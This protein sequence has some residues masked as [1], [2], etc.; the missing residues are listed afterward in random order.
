MCAYKSCISKTACTCAYDV[1]PASVG[2]A[3]CRSRPAHQRSL[4]SQ[5]VRGCFRGGRAPSATCFVGAHPPAGWRREVRSEQQK[6]V[7]ATKKGTR[8]KQRVQATKKG[9]YCV[10]QDKTCQVS[11]IWM[12][13]PDLGA[14]TR[15][16]YSTWSHRYGERATYYKDVVEWRHTGPIFG[17][18]NAVES[19]AITHTYSRVREEKEGTTPVL[20]FRL[21][22]SVLTNRS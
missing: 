9:V 10:V 12:A 16:R 8:D 3:W 11:A 1:S 14:N 5:W 2:F 7:Q 4:S 17:E 21:I 20:I 18:K 15:Y 22:K 13:S 6:G 19:I